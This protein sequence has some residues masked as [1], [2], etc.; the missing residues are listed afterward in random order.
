MTVWTAKCILLLYNRILYILYT[1]PPLTGVHR[2][3]LLQ[4]NDNSNEFLL[5]EVYNSVDAPARHK[6]TA[7]YSEWAVKVEGLMA[8]KRKS[9]KYST[10]FPSPLHYSKSS[11]LVY[12]GEGGGMYGERAKGEGAAPWAGKKGLSSAMPVSVCV[13]VCVCVYVCVC[14]CVCMC[15]CLC[16]CMCVCVC[17]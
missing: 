1:P 7:H 12:A 14:M 3:D 13:C 8:E 2:F 6:N 10:L 16:V 9:L 4:S 15:V 11:G 17:V 5:I